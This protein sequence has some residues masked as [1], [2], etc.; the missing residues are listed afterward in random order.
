M[1]RIALVMTMAASLTLSAHQAMSVEGAKPPGRS[2]SFDGLF[3][4]FDR[5]AL[6]RGYQ[7]FSESCASCHSLKRVAYRNLSEIGFSEDQVK[8]IA[9]EAE[10]TDGPNEE[11]EMYQR[12]GKP[13]DRFVKPFPNDNAA[14]AANNGAM[15]PDL[16]LITKARAGGVDYL[17]AI[18]TGYREAPKGVEIG[19]NMAYNAYFPG[20]AIAMP[21]PLEDDQVEYADKTKATV[22]RMSADVT[23]FLAWASEPELEARKRMGIKVMLFLLVLTGMLYAVKRKVWADL[24]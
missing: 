2:W 19:E 16:S 7:V 8:K 13:S 4:T 22:E 1:R 17:H 23:T 18:L 9:A 24:H 14:R 10:V 11:G 6:Q 12:K 5:G 20:N 21:P 3:G 15:P